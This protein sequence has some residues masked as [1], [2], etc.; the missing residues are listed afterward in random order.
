MVVVKVGFSDRVIRVAKKIIVAVKRA[1]TGRIN[2]VV[3]RS[4]GQARL[5]AQRQ[6]YPALDRIGKFLLIVAVA[7][8]PAAE[9]NREQRAIVINH[10]GAFRLQSL[11]HRSPLFPAR[12]RSFLNLPPTIRESDI[13]DHSK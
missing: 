6:V 7:F 8:Q 1:R 13:P 10:G 3:A 5:G 11:S 9:A 4:R 12:Y 2:A